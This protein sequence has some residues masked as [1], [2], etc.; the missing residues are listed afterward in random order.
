[1]LNKLPVFTANDRR[2]EFAVQF[3]PGRSSLLKGFCYKKQNKKVKQQIFPERWQWRMLEKRN[4]LEDQEYIAERGKKTKEMEDL[5][6]KYGSKL[7]KKF[8][9]GQELFN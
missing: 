7:Q 1:M 3:F 8:D 5:A 6:K 9:G 2:K 4:I